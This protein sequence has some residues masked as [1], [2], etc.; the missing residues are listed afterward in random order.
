MVV[1]LKIKMKPTLGRGVID[2]T[3]IFDAMQNHWA[4]LQESLEALPAEERTE[5]EN[6]FNSVVEDADDLGSLLFADH[7]QF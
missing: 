1:K 3:V 5:F 2:Q 7:A 6:H 4:D